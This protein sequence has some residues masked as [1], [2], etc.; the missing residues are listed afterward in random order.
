MGIYGK[1]CT[2]L[3]KNAG[4]ING[5]GNIL[6]MEHW[7]MGLESWLYIADESPFIPQWNAIIPDAKT[8]FIQ[9]DI[10]SG[11][12]SYLLWPTK[13]SLRLN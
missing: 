10:F 12:I 13:L 6:R 5:R 4:I 9:E 7:T 1:L 3:H 8:S 11:M 2:K